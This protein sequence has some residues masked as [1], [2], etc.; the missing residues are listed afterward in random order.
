MH[1][2]LPLG[3]ST[4]PKAR[5]NTLQVFVN[6]GVFDNGKKHIAVPSDICCTSWDQP[7]GRK[8]HPFFCSVK[9]RDCLFNVY[10]CK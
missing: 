5:W 10:V 4:F 2:T 9:S 7:M 3:V 8:D 6:L 1:K